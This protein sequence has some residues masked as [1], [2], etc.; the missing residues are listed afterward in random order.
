MKSL[1]AISAILVLSTSS[2][3]M[4]D[5]STDPVHGK[6]IQAN[7]QAMRELAAARGKNPPEVTHYRY[8]TKLD[9]DKVINVTSTK[10]NCNVMP[11]QMT[12]VDSS[13]ELN[14]L[15]YRVAGINCQ[16]QN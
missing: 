9:I 11:A 12:Y 16:N 4:A 8:G 6:M 2:F 10:K 14:I 7:E 5:G 1:I 15:E 13:G 3:A